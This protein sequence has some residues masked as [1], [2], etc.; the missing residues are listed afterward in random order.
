MTSSFDNFMKQY[1]KTGSEKADG[2]SR[3]V[4]IGLSDQEESIVFDLLMRELPFSAEWLFFLNAEKALA[5]VKKKEERL[6]GD[7]Y[8]SNY[9]LQ[10]ELIK[11]TGDLSYQDRMIE[12]Y[13][14]YTDNK[15]PLV[16][17][18]IGRTPATAAT[19]NF[20]KNVIL[21]EVNSSAVARAARALMSDLAIPRGTESEENTYHRIVSD[22]RNEVLDVKLRAL[23]QI[24]PFEVNLA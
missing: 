2:Y 13:P 9:L 16:V 19:I 4:F 12:S 23:R 17:D 18:A 22:L 11:F 3:D 8:A 7:G 6:R 14:G 15:K 10:E 24:E 21:T 1:E 5:V 20:F